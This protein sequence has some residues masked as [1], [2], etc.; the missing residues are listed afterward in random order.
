MTFESVKV[1][2]K[3]SSIVSTQ[4]IF[5]KQRIKRVLFL[6]NEAESR[7][8]RYV[9]FFLLLQV[10]V[11]R[12]LDSSQACLTSCVTHFASVIVQ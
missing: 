4:G 12:L 5:K 2:G 6:S 3:K 8:H 7:I 9:K 11:R 1:F 10:R